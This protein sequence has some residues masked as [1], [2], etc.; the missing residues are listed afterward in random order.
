[1]TLWKRVDPAHAKGA[2]GFALTVAQ[3]EGIQW[4]WPILSSGAEHEVVFIT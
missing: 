1:M 2:A 3:V 4:F